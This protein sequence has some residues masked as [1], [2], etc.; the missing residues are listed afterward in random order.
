MFSL[1][2]FKM[3]KKQSNIFVH[4]LGLKQAL[5][6]NIFLKTWL[7]WMHKNMYNPYNN[8]IYVYFSGPTAQILLSIVSRNKEKLWK[9][10]YSGTQKQGR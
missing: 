3:Q 2:S 10:P 1:K 8:I 6:S 4:F 5:Q 9:G 7:I